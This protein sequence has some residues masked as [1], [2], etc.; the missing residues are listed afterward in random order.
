[1]G[2]QQCL[3]RLMMVLCVF[4]QTINGA[5]VITLSYCSSKV[6]FV[7]VKWRPYYLSREFTPCSL[8]WSTFPLALMWRKV[9]VNTT[10]LSAMYEQCTPHFSWLDPISVMLVPL[11]RPLMKCAKPV[12]KQVRTWSEEVISVLQGWFE[13]TNWNMFREAATYNHT[14][15]LEEYASFGGTHISDW[16]NQHIPKWCDFLQDH[17]HFTNQEIVDGGIGAGTN[18]I[19][20]QYFWVWWQGSPPHSKGQSFLGYQRNYAKII[21]NHFLNTKDTQLMRQCIQA[22]TRRPEIIYVLPE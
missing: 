9:K 4:T 21:H 22:I 11:Y 19:L 18:E 10:W 6:D 5:A 2:E 8:L 13:H 3:V 1:M 14:T 17:H 7:T 12:L 15:D 16:L 20:R